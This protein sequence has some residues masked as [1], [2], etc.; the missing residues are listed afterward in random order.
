MAWR[1]RS[2]SSAEP[3]AQGGIKILGTLVE[4]GVVTKWNDTENIW[5][6]TSYKELRVAPGGHPV[7]PTD[8]LLNPKANRERMTQMIFEIFNVHAMYMATQTIL[9]LYASGRTTGLV[10]DDGLLHTVPIYEGYAVRHANLRLDLAGRD[11]SDYLM[12]ILTERRYSFTTTA[13][14]EIGRDVKEKLC[15]IA[16]DYDTELKIARGKFRQQ[17]D[18]HALRRKH[19][20]RRRTFPL[21]ECFSSQFSFI[22]IKASG[23]HDTSFHY[24]TKCDVDLRKNLYAMTCSQVARTCSKGLLSA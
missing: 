15:Y 19:Q 17:S 9:S 12:K 16:F 1:P 4:H 21:H 5:H 18:L 6:H 7:L 2:S 20:C 11:L 14:R 8:A 24:F 3:P 22:G 23:V 10:M 13:E